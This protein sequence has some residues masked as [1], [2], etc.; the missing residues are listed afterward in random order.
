M[1]VSG[2]G[3]ILAM[4]EG[5]G[6]GLQDRLFSSSTAHVV[7]QN[8][9]KKQIDHPKTQLGMGLH[10]ELLAPSWEAECSLLPAKCSALVCC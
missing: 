4:E 10:H 3:V 7:S 6:R 5:L 9:E 1:C 8:R 2:G